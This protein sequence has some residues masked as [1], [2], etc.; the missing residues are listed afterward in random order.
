MLITLLAA[1]VLTSAGVSDAAD[2]EAIVTTA[3][4]GEQSVAL[5]AVAPVAAEVP[6]VSAQAITPHGLTTAEQIDRWVRQRSNESKPFSDDAPLDPWGQRDD[7]K[8]HGEVSAAV[9][10]GDY[11]AWSATVSYPIG[12]TG[13]LDL[14][15]S[16]SKNSPYAY[17]YGYGHP[18]YGY[19][20]FYSGRRLGASTQSFGVSYQS[21][22]DR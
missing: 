15:Y 21:D 3:P 11:T 12:E 6:A 13:R 16:Q 2:P 10:T 7:R 5:D 20:P 4:H 1:A 19:E 9:G 17:G 14:S 18:G 8:I 22:S